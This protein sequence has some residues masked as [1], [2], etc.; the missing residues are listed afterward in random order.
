MGGGGAKQPCGVTSSWAST[1]DIN[2]SY[3]LALSSLC[4]I[5]HWDCDN[6]YSVTFTAKSHAATRLEVKSL[7]VALP[8][9]KF[10]LHKSSRNH[11][12]ATLCLSTKW[13]LNW[14]CINYCFFYVCQFRSHQIF[15]PWTR[16]FIPML[17]KS[18][19]SKQVKKKP[20]AKLHYSDLW[21]PQTYGSHLIPRGFSYCHK[22][23]QNCEERG[24]QMITAVLEEQT[25]FPH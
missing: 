1:S 20:F 15:L 19:K 7:S 14:T 10:Q 9:P 13:H 8:L 18:I 22:R 21:F 23:L 5:H 2:V 6:C 11:H 16:L 3:A 4:G 24:K 12:L 25:N 17:W